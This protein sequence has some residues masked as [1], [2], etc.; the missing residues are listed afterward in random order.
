MVEDEED[1]SED[2]DDLG[3]IV[4]YNKELHLDLLQ[5]VMERLQVSIFFK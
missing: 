2:E 5:E 3:R 1:G 4:S